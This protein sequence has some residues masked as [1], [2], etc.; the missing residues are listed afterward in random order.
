MVMVVVNVEEPDMTTVS[1]VEATT[2]VVNTSVKDVPRT[3]SAA[4]CAIL[5]PA[6]ALTGALLGAKVISGSA[7]LVTKVG[8]I[9]IEVRDGTTATEFDGDGGRA[10]A[11]V[12]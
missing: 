3:E 9:L 5:A 1:N 2:L 4:L 11:K 10:T 6:P 12:L 8:K 7:P